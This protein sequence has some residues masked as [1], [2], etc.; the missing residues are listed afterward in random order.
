MIN[1]IPKPQLVLGYIEFFNEPPPDD[2]LS[3]ALTRDAWRQRW[4]S[5]FNELTSIEL[6]QKSWLDRFNKNSH[7]SFVE[8]MCSYF[9][10]LT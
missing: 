7:W 3:I 5:S 1:T 4:L 8:F 10:N 9:D 6:Q 2:R